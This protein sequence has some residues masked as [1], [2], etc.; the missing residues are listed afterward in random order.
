MVRLTDITRKNGIISCNAYVED[1]R[2]PIFLSFDEKTHSFDAFE[3]P[4]GYGYCDW[5]ILIYA[6]RF[7]ISAA[8]LDELP[9]QKLIM[10]Y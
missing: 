9:S 4:A 1:C 8:D 5:H 2:Q 7:L 10:W 3:L 6:R